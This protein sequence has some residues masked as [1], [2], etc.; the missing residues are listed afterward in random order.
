VQGTNGE[1][2]MVCAMRF[3]LPGTSLRRN[4]RFRDKRGGCTWYGAVAGSSFAR[5]MP[6][7]GLQKLNEY[8]SFQ[9]CKGGKL[10]NGFRLDSHHNTPTQ[11]VPSP[12]GAA[13]S[14]PG[15]VNGRMLLCACRLLRR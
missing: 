7:M 15:A 2:L 10:V 4:S 5:R 6:M 8:L 14:Q 13:A 12:H 3:Q 11:H 1:R 9:H